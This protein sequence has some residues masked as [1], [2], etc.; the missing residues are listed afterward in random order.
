MASDSK[1]DIRHSPANGSSE[2]NASCCG[3]ATRGGGKRRT[4]SVER[5]PSSLRIKEEDYHKIYLSGAPWWRM[6]LLAGC[7][8]RAARARQPLHDPSA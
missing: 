3:G 1:P 6:R 5:R 2:P 8:V 4:T 7:K